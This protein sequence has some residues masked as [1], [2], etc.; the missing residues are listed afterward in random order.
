MLCLGDAVK[1]CLAKENLFTQ[2]Y[3]NKILRT[4][5]VAASVGIT[6]YIDVLII[7]VAFIIKLS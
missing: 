6:H 7:Y 4:S 1:G 2:T 5:T 3:T